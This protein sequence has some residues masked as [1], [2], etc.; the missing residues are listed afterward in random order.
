MDPARKQRRNGILTVVGVLM[1]VCA[2]WTVLVP[3]TERYKSYK[4][5]ANLKKTLRAITLPAGAE[6]ILINSTHDEDVWT[7]M[8]MYSA[9]SRVDIV[10][11]HYMQEFARHGFV[12]KGDDTTESQTFSKFCAPA[13]QAILVSG[14]AERHPLVYS[15]FLIRKDTTC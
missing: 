11:S 15:I 5:E 14:K 4:Q 6:V 13:Y 7:A 1:V 3:R 12:Y 9:D 8:G 10:K 2:F